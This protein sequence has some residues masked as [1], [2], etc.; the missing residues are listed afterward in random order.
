MSST[1]SLERA[2]LAAQ[3]VRMSTDRQQYSIP[4]QTEVLER[5]AVEHGLRIIKSYAD[6]G[7]SGLH[8]A[9]RH[10]LAGLLA[11]VE[12][13]A[14]NYAHILVY[15]IS[16]WGRF[17]DC[18]ES[19]Y[20]EFLCRRAGVN[21]H[22]CAETFANDGSL[23][24]TI[25][26]AIRRVMAGEFSRE[27]SRR[28][29]H[30]QCK[31]AEQG[32][33]RGSKAPYGFRRQII[34]L[35]G[36]PLGILKSGEF[37]ARTKDHVTLVLGPPEEVGIVREIYRRFTRL[38]ENP[39]LISTQINKIGAPSWSGKRWAASTVANMLRNEI[40]AGTYRFNMT[41]FSL[42]TKRQVNDRSRWIIKEA[43]FPAIVS[44]SMLAKARAEFKEQARYSTDRMLEGLQQVLTKHGRLSRSLI[45]GERGLPH[46]ATY[47]RHF[48]SLIDAYH[49]IGYHGA[50]EPKQTVTDRRHAILCATAITLADYW[51]A[52]PPTLPSH[53]ATWLRHERGSLSYIIAVLRADRFAPPF[54]EVNLVSR[55]ATLTLL[56]QPDAKHEL[57]ARYGVARVSSSGKPC[58]IVDDGWVKWTRR[59]DGAAA[60]LSWGLAEPA[61]FP[62]IHARRIVPS[63]NM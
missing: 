10:G 39:H 60:E 47:V 31:L 12:S 23:P 35:E 54:Y 22:Y 44:K 52:P 11:D 46:P 26:K 16:R 1:Y 20:Y 62:L 33:W 25:A 24:G 28:V 27:L 34:G 48:G 15:D 30:T 55:V 8:L 58:V 32:Y 42:G 57:V 45:E 49:R 9:G 19:A 7:K 50:D 61:N 41:S 18:D 43:A 13:G 4:Y 29:F 2:S 5:Y 21:V 53:N 51:R 17:Q 40:Y 59:L 14:A 38:H 37:K 36:H 63:M 6:E 56:V 3:Y